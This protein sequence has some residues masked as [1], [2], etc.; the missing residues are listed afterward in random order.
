MYPVLKAVQEK[1]G[2]LCG[3]DNMICICGD[4][5]DTSS[6]RCYI[7][8]FKNGY[9]SH[10][11]EASFKCLREEAGKEFCEALLYNYK[12]S[13]S[14]K[15]SENLNITLCFLCDQT[16]HVMNDFYR[17]SHGLTYKETILKYLCKNC[18]EER[19]GT[20]F[21]QRKIVENEKRRMQD[22]VKKLII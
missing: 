13:Y 22:L 17:F 2:C 10:A 6:V 15:H 18:F 16:I 1:I 3:I 20:D 9:I 5:H 11:L 21:F 7:T 8:Q 19:A 14:S 4:K 12:H